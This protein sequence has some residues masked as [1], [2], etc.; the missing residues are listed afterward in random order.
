MDCSIP[1]FPVLPCLLEFAQTSVCW[2]DDAIQPSHP[3]LPLFPPVLN[4]SQHQGLSNES[5]LCIRWPKYWT[6]SF[7]ISP[8]NE[9]STLKMARIHRK[10]IQKRSGPENLA[11]LAFSAA[12][13]YNWLNC[14]KKHDN[15]CGRFYLPKIALVRRRTGGKGDDRG[16]DCWMASP[17]PWTWVWASSRSWW[18]TGRP[19]V[20]QSIGSWRLD[21]TER[22]NWTE[23]RHINLSSSPCFSGTL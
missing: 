21:M 8:S 23:N 6:F 7:N 1:A 5:A 14:K 17:T 10:S 12:T 15:S 4:L 2:V 18:W 3:L 9:Y 22:L 16:W 11:H 20:L 19:G 13:G